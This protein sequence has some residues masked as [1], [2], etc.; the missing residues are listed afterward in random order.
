M[1]EG[2]NFDIE[3]DEKVCSISSAG[4]PSD[5]QRL[6]RLV[7]NSRYVCASCGRTANHEENLCAPEE[8]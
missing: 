6:R 7:R 2:Q 4:D 8:L 1:D 5:L 3:S